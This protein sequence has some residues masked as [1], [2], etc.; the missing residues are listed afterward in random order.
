[1]LNVIKPLIDGGI[2]S[3]DTQKAISEAWEQQL[4]EVREQIRAEMR[5]EFAQRYSHDKQAMVEAL[6]KLVTE[7][8]EAEIAE[9]AEEKSKLRRERVEFKKFTREASE[10]FN[11]FMV[12]KLTEEIAEFRNQRKQQRNATLRMQEYVREALET[13]ISEFVKDRRSLVQAKVRLIAEGKKRLAEM[14]ARFVK[15]SSKLVQEAVTKRLQSEIKQ[16]KEDITLARE[17][18]FGRRLFEAFASEFALSHLN[19]NQEIKKLRSLVKVKDRQVEEVKQLAESAKRE[20]EAKEREIRVIK[21]NAQRREIMSDLLKPLNKEKA[22]IM[23]ELLESVQTANLRSAYEKYLPAVLNNGPTTSSKKTL[24]ESKVEVTGDKT[25]K[26][27]SV[28]DAD[29]TDNNVV[30]LRRLAGLK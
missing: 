20:I 1:M 11:D 14:Q 23:K 4:N 25:A 9:F 28:S 18:M 24:V 26:A 2:I 16:L 12:K 6:D 7:S 22:E 10:K 17:N 3:E 13:E 21:E 15:R 29:D 19:E 27:H 8:L 30:E 5:D